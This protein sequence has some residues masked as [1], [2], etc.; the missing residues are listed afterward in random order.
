[1][2]V[3]L[4]L[5]KV[6]T[7]IIPVI[8]LCVVTLIIA[9]DVVGR[10]VFSRPIFGASEIALISF[11]WMVWLGIVAVA[12]SG[13]MMGIVYFVDRLGPLR[14]PAMILS[15][16]LILGIV[17]FGV[18][19]CYRQ[20]STARFTVF[21]ALGLPKWIL[22]VG[23]GVSFV[24]LIAVYCDKLYRTIKGRSAATVTPEDPL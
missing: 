4:F 1:M 9:A 11:V 13:E 6:L 17:G 18:Y 10:G 3:W 8:L 16:V 24:C 5:T 15:D 23:V 19:A 12:R 14:R 7:E 20:V 21:E 2:R 22:A